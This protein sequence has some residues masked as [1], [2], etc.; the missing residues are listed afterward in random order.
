GGNAAAAQE[1][2]FD[3]CAASTADQKCI[4]NVSG[5]Y[6]CKGTAYHTG[7]SCGSGGAAPL[8]EGAVGPDEAPSNYNDTKPCVYASSNGVATCISESKQGKE[9][10]HCGSVNGVQTCVDSPPSENG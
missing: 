2:C 6:R 5:A 7:Q 3:G 4:T 9:G 10:R 8:E 1:G